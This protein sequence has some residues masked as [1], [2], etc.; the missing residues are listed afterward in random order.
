LGNI[1]TDQFLPVTILAFF[2][3]VL[4]FQPVAC[5]IMVKRRNIEPDNLKIPAK[6][7]TM[8]L[9]AGFPS[10]L[11]IPVITLSA[12]YKVIN[13]RMAFQASGCRFLF[14]EHMAFG[15]V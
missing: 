3:P 12:F 7:F 9:M 14:S 6:M 2:R 1:K 11:G 15:T 5:Q 10:S 13:F 8:A 4:T